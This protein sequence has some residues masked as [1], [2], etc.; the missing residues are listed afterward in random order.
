M[1]FQDVFQIELFVLLVI[2]LVITLIGFYRLVYFISVGYGYSIAGMAL[3]MLIK[4]DS[5]S[6]TFILQAILLIIYGLRL[7]TFLIYRDMRQSYKQ[8]LD[9]IKAHN[10]STPIYKY[11]AIWI[12]VCLLYVLMFMPAYSRFIYE[13]AEYTEKFP[14]LGIIGILIMASGILIETIADIQKTIFKKSNPKSF[15]SIG[16]YKHVRCPNYFGEVLFWVGNMLT[17]AMIFGH[18]ILIIGSLIGFVCI[19]LIMMGSTKRL[20]FKQDNR[21]GHLE[22]YVTYRHSVPVLIPF[23]PVYTLKNIKVYLE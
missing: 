2:S 3:F 6:I 5:P 7:G 13:N 16:L 4:G 19:I 14:M 12:G 23:I 10:K 18:F 1:V 8:E 11:F 21:Y 20:E 15:C 22:A 17:G 9:Q